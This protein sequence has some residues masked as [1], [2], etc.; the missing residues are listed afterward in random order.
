MLANVES[1]IG[2]IKDVSVLQRISLLQPFYNPFDQLVHS[3][4]SS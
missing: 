3:L 1:M 4:E 2:S